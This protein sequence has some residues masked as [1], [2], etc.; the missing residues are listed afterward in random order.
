MLVQAFV[1]VLH[2]IPDVFGR[3]FDTL[4]SISHHKRTKARQ[5]TNTYN[6]NQRTTIVNTKEHKQHTETKQKHIRPGLVTASS[7]SSSPS[8]L[9]FSCWCMDAPVAGD[10]CACIGP[11]ITNGCPGTAWVMMIQPLCFKSRRAA[12]RATQ[13]AECGNDVAR[14]LLGFGKRTRA[15]STTMSPSALGNVARLEGNAHRPGSGWDVGRFC[16]T[17]ILADVTPP[18][19]GHHQR[20]CRGEGSAR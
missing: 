6:R 13:G 19:I 5:T 14:S 12:G 7:S 11:P 20:R 1:Y 15:R 17:A 3:M 4:G 16:S 9:S 2:M 10:V 8:S 18:G